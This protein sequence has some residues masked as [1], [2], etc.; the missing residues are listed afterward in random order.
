MC[1]E[2]RSRAAAG[3]WPGHPDGAL[4]VVAHFLVPVYQIALGV[5]VVNTVL[6]VL[7]GGLRSALRR[8]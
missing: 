5:Y 7:A 1:G 8:R 2:A 6:D 4:T 3:A